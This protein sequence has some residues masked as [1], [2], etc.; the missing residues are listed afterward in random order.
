[1]GKRDYAL[2]S[3]LL[4][5]GIRRA[6]AASLQLGDFSTEQ[7]YHVLTIRH[8]KGD[9]RRKAKIPV[10]VMRVISDYL[11]TTSRKQA[12]LSAPLFIG[13]TRGGN[14]IERG[15]SEKAIEKIVKRTA[16][17]I[18][19][20]LTPHG[21]RASFVT[22]ALEGGQSSSRCSMLPVMQTHALQRDTKR[23][24]STW[25]TMRRII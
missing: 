6:E 12:G 7:G 9:K 2:I 20:D 25:T 10:D 5:T 14:I 19:V 13:F 22:L 21:L 24:N 15:L 18:N 11:E 4:R 1:M 16:E 3:L 23:G 17:R 8:G